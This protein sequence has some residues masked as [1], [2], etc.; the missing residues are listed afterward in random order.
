MSVLSLLP[1]I[2]CIVILICEAVIGENWYQFSK[3]D[4]WRNPHHHHH[5][6]RHH[7]ERF[8][9]PDDGM[10][11]DDDQRRYQFDMN[12]YEGSIWHNNDRPAKTI[13]DHNDYNYF[14]FP[15]ATTETTTTVASVAVPGMGTRRSSC[16]DRC[17]ATMQYDPIC[18][19]NGIT[20][21]N[22]QWFKCALRCGRRVQ[23]R[24]RGSCPRTG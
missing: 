3:R 2:S 16:E 4:D 21:T 10:H 5:P 8:F 13:H 24:Y 12:R 17:P 19:D 20:Y 7:D 15:P 9:F 1:R 22:M 6:D 14:D 18:G 23:M 11:F